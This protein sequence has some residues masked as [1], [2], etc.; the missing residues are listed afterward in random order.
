MDNE[1]VRVLLA[2]VEQTVSIMFEQYAPDYLIYHNIDHTRGVVAHAKEIAANY[3]LSLEEFFTLVAAA[4]FHDTGQIFSAPQRH[5]E[6]SIK[7]A[8]LYFSGQKSIPVNLITA[9]DHCILA[10]R[11]PQ[12]PHT[13]IEEILC[14]AD[15]YH[16]GTASFFA[17]DKA[18]K[19]EAMLR[20]LDVSN[21]EQGTLKLMQSHHFHTAYCQDKLNAGKQNNLLM[22]LKRQ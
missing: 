19:E 15:L 10:T 22:L 21:W 13:L 16:L 5:E 1:Q 20:G 9:I 14:D 18:V 2:D 8:N 3:D 11:M 7:I 17:V 4:W 6:E 12:R